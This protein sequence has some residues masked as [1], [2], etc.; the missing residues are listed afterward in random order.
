MLG[1]SLLAQGKNSEAE[2]EFRAVLAE[3]L[4]TARSLAW[5]NVGLADIASKAGQ[6]D[7]AQKYA[8]AAILADGDYGASLMARNLRNKLGI[9]TAADAAIKAF[10]ADFD[11]AAS[12]NRKADV[13][14][15]VMPGE[16][17]KFAS[18]VSGATE[19]WQTQVRQVD[20]LDADTVLV[21]AIM[22]VKL[23][24]KDVQTGLAVYRL[25]KTAGGWKLNAVEMFEL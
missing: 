1:R 18:G 5:A 11:K 8:E 19:Q 15:L 3:K 25:V 14:A 12:S 20:R 17:T 24:N 13:D 9:T 22:T 4:P 6:T 2:K 7:A 23:L 10:F 16:V 21:E